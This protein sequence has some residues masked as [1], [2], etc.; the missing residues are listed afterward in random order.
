MPL[1]LSIASKNTLIQD[2]L[3]NMLQTCVYDALI[4]EL[5]QDNKETFLPEYKRRVEEEYKMVRDIYIYTI[6]MVL[7]EAQEVV[8]S[9]CVIY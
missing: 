7:T 2:F 6:Q 5:S 3:M 1:K 9:V 8:L 4:A